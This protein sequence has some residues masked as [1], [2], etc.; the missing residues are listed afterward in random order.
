MPMPALLTGIGL[1]AKIIS[2]I[3]IIKIRSMIILEEKIYEEEIPG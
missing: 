2:V 3:F 1:R